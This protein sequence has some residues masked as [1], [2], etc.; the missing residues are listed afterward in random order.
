MATAVLTLAGALLVIVG[1]AR[2]FTNGVE[3]IG[4]N[5]GLGEGA[6]GSVLAA[7]GTATPESMVPI[8]AIL[9]GASHHSTEVGVG[10]ILGAPFLLATLG[11]FLNGMAVTYYHWRGR[12]RRTVNPDRRV[13]QRDLRFFLF[14]YAL[15]ISAAFISLYIGKVLVSI[16]L[17]TAYALFVRAA[18]VPQKEPALAVAAADEQVP[19][20]AMHG[21]D[22][23][24]LLV[25]QMLRL[26]V[27]P[28]IWLSVGQAL[29]GLGLIVLGA[30]YFADT[31]AEL[32]LALGISA[33]ILSVLI[34]PAATELPEVF[35]SVLWMGMRKDTL[36]I[37]NVTGAMVFQS[38]VVPVVGILLTPWRL[39]ALHL[40]SAILAYLAILYTYAIFRWRKTVSA[41]FLFVNGSFYAVYLYL[42]MG[43]IFSF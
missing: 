36:A 18:L 16:T 5:L 25:V 41:G 4:K 33:F 26:P 31:I 42:V 37:G 14:V 24:P 22:M 1:G 34:T 35:N 7:I 32:S 30:K 28:G 17:L 23:D 15:A 8:I 27:S 19:H 6:V 40:G 20:A 13:V 43:G 11:F 2:L 39:D 9:F 3:W 10:A 12:R 29:V 38:S 21:G